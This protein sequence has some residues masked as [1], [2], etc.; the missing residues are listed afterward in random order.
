MPDLS[1]DVLTQLQILLRQAFEGPQ[2][3]SSFTDDNPESGLTGTLAKLSAAQ[4]SR[5]WAGSTIAAHVHHVA[6]GMAAQGARVGGDR[7]SRDWTESWSV[8]TVDEAGWAQLL[9]E[10]Q[11]R[12]QELHAILEEHALDDGDT[13][14]FALDAIAH[15]IYHLGSI[16]QKVAAGREG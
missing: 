14:G 12:R 2:R 15:V 9:A 6:F 4:A 7:R 10:L 13:L 11:K 8:Q 16:R 3:E 1:R 5:S